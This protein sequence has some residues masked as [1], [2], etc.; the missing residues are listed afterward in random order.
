MKYVCSVSWEVVF[1]IGHNK[2]YNL[3]DAKNKLFLVSAVLGRYKKNYN[4]VSAACVN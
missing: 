3:Y 4:L 1:G 2:R